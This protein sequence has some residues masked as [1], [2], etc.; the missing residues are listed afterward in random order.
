VSIDPRAALRE[1]KR[2]GV[3]SERRGRVKLETGGYIPRA[4]VIEKLDILGRDGAEF[5]SVMIHNVERAATPMLQRKASYDNI[6]SNSLERLRK[7]LAEEGR[8][9][10][11][12]ANRLLARADR[13][14]NPSAPRGRRTRVSFG[15][16]F[17]EEPVADAGSRLRNKTKR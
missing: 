8:D 3:V 5:L 13:D 1:L 16:Y 2:V 4:G 11:E 12:A 9:A 15:V 6:G 14:R 10:V 7:S 17:F